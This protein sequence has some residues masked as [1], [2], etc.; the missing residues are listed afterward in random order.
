MP[1]EEP[2]R[3]LSAIMFPDIFG[4]TALMQ[5]NEEAIVVV[6]RHEQVLEKAVDFRHPFSPWIGTDSGEI[7]SASFKSLKG[8]P[9]FQALLKRINPPYFSAVN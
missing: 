6:N 9:R 5:H 1:D 8:E 2:S 7:T 3:R 4:Y